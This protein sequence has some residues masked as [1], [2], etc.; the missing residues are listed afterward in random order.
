MT[1]LCTREGAILE[2]VWILDDLPYTTFCLVSQRATNASL[3]LLEDLMKENFNGFLIALAD[4]RCVIR[5]LA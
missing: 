3:N 4:V 2:A 5:L 1:A